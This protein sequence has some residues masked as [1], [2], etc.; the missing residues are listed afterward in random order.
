M[1]S[2]FLESGWLKGP[3]ITKKPSPARLKTN[4][5]WILGAPCLA[6][7]KLGWLEILFFLATV[8]A[9]L[10]FRR[11]HV[12]LV[13]FRS[14]LRCMSFISFP[15]LK[16]SPSPLQE[17]MPSLEDIAIKHM[18]QNILVVLLIWPQRIMTFR[19]SKTTQVSIKNKMNNLILFLSKYNTFS[20][21]N[22][23]ISG[24]NCHK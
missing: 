3:C 17:V 19:K 24:N 13:S 6:F 14:L 11:R 12:N 2:Y 8:T 1:R 7:M 16:E 22:H 4:E 21:A 18:Y 10:T 15:S 20:K 5:S 9:Y 23:P